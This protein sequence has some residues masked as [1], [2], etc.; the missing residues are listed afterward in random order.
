MIERARDILANSSKYT[1]STIEGLG[2]VLEEAEAVYN[3]ENANQ[4][5]V[6]AATEVLTRELAK[7]RLKGD[8]DGNGKIDT[9]DTWILLK[10]NA[11]LAH[12]SDEQL[13][14]AD[15]NGDGL[16]DTKDVV[17]ILQYASE[18]IEAF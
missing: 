16:V 3:D 6:N 15:V 12:L 5:Q 8:V 7:V 10:H 14:G 17:L 18:E 9:S 11:E 1:P 4:A 13:E 2:E